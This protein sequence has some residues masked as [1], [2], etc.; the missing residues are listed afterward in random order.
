MQEHFAMHEELE[1]RE[2]LTC[3]SK[4]NRPQESEM[5]PRWTCTHAHTQIASNTRMQYARVAS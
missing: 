3:M 2:I 1:L 5:D 4:V